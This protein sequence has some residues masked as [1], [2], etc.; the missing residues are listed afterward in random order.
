MRISFLSL[1]FYCGSV[2]AQTSSAFPRGVEHVIVV[3][4][5]AMSPDGIRTAPTP[6]MHQLM[7]QGA[8]K[9]NVRTVLPSTSAANWA[10]MIMGAGTEA[11]G[12]T[13]ND[14]GRTKYTLPPLVSDD[15]DIFPT[16]FGWIRRN[17]PSAEIGTVYQWGGFGGLFEKTAVNYDKHMPDEVSTTNTF[18]AYVK[19]KKPLFAFMHLD[20]VDDVGHEYG[21]GTDLYYQAVTKADS[22]I[23]L[24]VKA[25]KDAGIQNNTLLIITADHG[26]IGYGHGGATTEEA[27]I[28]MILSGK[29]IKKGYRIQQQVY[30]YDLAATIAFALRIVP[31]YAWTG[32]PI[33]PA[34][35]GF[36]EPA[37]LY[38]GKTMI[39]YPKI[40]PWRNLYKKAGGLYIDRVATVSMEA[41]APGAETRF[42]TDG[43]QP[44]PASTLY[45]RPFIID[46]T[47][48]VRA[49]S[50]D[51]AGNASQ[52][53]AAFYR[54]ASSGQ[55]HG[56][57]A[58][59][60][61]GHDWNH[62]PVLG[63]MTGTHEWNSFEFSLNRDQLLP[64]I[65]KEASSFGILME[66]FLKIDLAGKYSFYTQSDD[67]SKLYIDGKEVVN[68]DGDHGVIERMGAVE[69]SAGQHKIGVAY[70][71]GGGSFWLDALY[72][73]P[74]V[75][76]QIIPAN[77]L[78]LR[79]Q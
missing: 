5:D 24:V 11:H 75:P 15:E 33:K 22:L 4:V 56:V 70:Y 78:F 12:V 53:V 38:M 16:I 65:G 46:T 57:K 77:K 73:G 79:E 71:N 50:F 13:D 44:G 28:A 17:R 34:F 6:V 10:S 63:T 48:V 59:F 68:N 32:R 42:T 67:G 69:L 41:M 39:A 61:P 35:I 72:S 58:I 1:L 31:P 8:V 49:R 3:G 7:Q 40:F 2:C 18:T 54:I 52:P 55:G 76:K 74:G 62:L 43:S 51:K 45:T 25:I 26:G 60:Y 47:T 23:G 14:Y 36:T 64:F 9:W 37:N 27:E 21:H 29:M 66:G 20:H 19:T 30:T